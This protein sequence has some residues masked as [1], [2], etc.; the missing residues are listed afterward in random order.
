MFKLKVNYLYTNFCKDYYIFEK[1]MQQQL[2]KIKLYW[3]LHLMH[4]FLIN[5]YFLSC[6]LRKFSNWQHVPHD[7]ATRA[8]DL[9]QWIRVRYFFI[10]VSLGRKIDE[11]LFAAHYKTLNKSF[12][13]NN[14][15]FFNYVSD[16]SNE[17]GFK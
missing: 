14:I 6:D 2:N 3:I 12:R 16:I 10:S 15:L 4:K 1:W 8:L 11:K 13:N 7:W 9:K 5:L 17:L